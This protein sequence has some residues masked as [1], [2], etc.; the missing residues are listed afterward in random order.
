MNKLCSVNGQVLN[1]RCTGKP[2]SYRAQARLPPL[3][4]SL[5][6]AVV[7]PIMA[8]F[9]DEIEIE[10]MDYDPDAATYYYPCPCG[11]R[12]QITLKVRE[13]TISHLPA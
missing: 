13:S 9:Y 12:F 11:D 3:V 4:W 8:A 10:D 2:V 1:M 5:C 7:E 6:L